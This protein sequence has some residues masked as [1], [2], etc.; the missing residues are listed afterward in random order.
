M[1]PRVAN[2]LTAGENPSGRAAEEVT[3]LIQASSFRLERIDSYGHASPPG[4][5]YD[6][7]EDEWV[8]LL[9][10]TAVMDFAGDGSLMLS[11]GDSLTIPARRKHRVEKVSEDAVW[12]ALHFCDPHVMQHP[13]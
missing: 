1:I 7:E 12:I 5:W 9:R 4:F 6:Q 3:P 11:A 13:A 10:G 2:L 8:V